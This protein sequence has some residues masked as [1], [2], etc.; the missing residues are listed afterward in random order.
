[1]ALWATQRLLPLTVDGEFAC[2]LAASHRAAIE[3]DRRI[4][5]SKSFLPFPR[6]PEL[7][8][9]VWRVRDE[10]VDNASRLAQRIFDRSATV[11]LH[12]ALVQL[13]EAIFGGNSG[14]AESGY[15]TC[16]RSVLMKPEH[17][18][19]MDQIWDRLQSA[20]AHEIAAIGK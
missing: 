14:A 6:T 15:V 9:V 8:I 1:V 5:N 13:P 19:W 12:L 3:L 10:N 18:E 17:E 7:D 16:L 11:N 4:R 20:T 2:G